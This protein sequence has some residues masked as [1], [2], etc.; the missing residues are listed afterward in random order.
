MADLPQHS[1]EAVIEK[2]EDGFA[3]LCFADKQTLR[4]PSAQLPNLAAGASVLV[5]VLP[6]EQLARDLLNTLLSEK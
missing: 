4:V 5:T 6:R 1:L 3:V 2:I